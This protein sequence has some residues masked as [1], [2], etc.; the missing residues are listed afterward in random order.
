MTIPMNSVNEADLK[1][2]R[3]ERQAE[4]QAGGDRDDLP[5]PYCKRPRSTRSDYIRCSFCGKNWP[6]GYGYDQS[7]AIAWALKDEQD[8]K[9][10][11]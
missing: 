8:R 9:D 5:C 10:R 11:S 2:L 3:D 6:I 4:I 7:P 1:A